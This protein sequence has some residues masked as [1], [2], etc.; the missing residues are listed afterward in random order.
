MK[1]V[2]FI[3]LSCL[4]FASCKTNTDL[5]NNKIPNKIVIAIYGS[6]G[7][8]SGSLRKAMDLMKDYLSK[9]LNKKVTF[10][11]STDYTGVIE[12]IHSKKAHIAYLSPFSY[13]LAAQKKDITPMVVVGSDGKMTLYHSVIFVNA[14]AGIN[15]IDDLKKKAK[16][17][18]LCFAD[19]ASASGHLIPN[20]YLSSIGLKPDSAFKQILFTG[21]H[22]ASILT[23]ASKKIDV[24]CTTQEYGLDIMVKKGLIKPGQLKVLWESEPIVG[25]PIVIRN[26]I[27]KEYAEKIKQIYLNLH[28]DNPAV[29]NAYLSLYHK[30]AATLSFVPIDDSAFNGIRTIANQTKDL[31]LFKK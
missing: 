27:N 20:G 22:A 28:K 23:V 8:N 4:L 29:F 17:L 16:S 14:D 7:D 10:Y 15:N 21:S 19:P 11:I 13:I 30:D 3:L 12:A 5:D 1:N 24:G 26:D 25:S 6:S 9:K 31:N 18:S 2:L